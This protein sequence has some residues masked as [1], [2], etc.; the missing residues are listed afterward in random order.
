MSE[1]HRG[2]LL[3]AALYL[4][5]ALFANRSVLA[6]PFTL[7]P[8]P[9]DF[10]EA[11]K[12]GRRL[13]YEADQRFVVSQVTRLARAF[14]SD[15]M[16]L[17]D[18]GLC[19]PLHHPHTLGEHMFAQ[20]LVGALPYAATEDPLF[21]FNMVS[22]LTTWISLMCMYALAYYWTG[23][24]AAAFIAGLL[25]G[26]HPQRL[27]NPAHL[28]GF[29][30]GWSAIALLAAHRLFDR[31]R[32]ADA[33]LLAAALCLQLLE[34]FYPV[35]GLGIIGGTYGL[36]LSVRYARRIPRLFPKLASVAAVVGGFAWLVLGPYL[37]TQAAWGVL[38]GRQRMLVWPWQYLPGG[39]ASLGWVAFVLALLSL[40]DRLR[41]PRVQDDPRWPLLVAGILV[42]WCSVWAIPLPFGLRVKSPLL[43][44]GPYIPG[45]DAVRALSALQ[46]E[47]FLVASI[48]AAFAVVAI[49]E[50]VPRRAHGGVAAVITAATLV[51]TFY[52]P[53]ARATFTLTPDL[54]AFPMRPSEE[55]LAALDRLPSGAVLD[56]PIGFEPAEKLRWMPKYLL[57]AAYY[58]RPTAACYNSFLSGLQSEV[59]RRARELPSRAAARE[60]SAL[61]FGSLRIHRGDIGRRGRLLAPLLFDD[62]YTEPIL[63]TPDTALFR[64]H[65]HRYTQEFA[66]IASATPPR[67][68][69]SV[70]RPADDLVFRFGRSEA[71]TFR[72]PDPIE[73]SEVVVRWR[74]EDG[75]LVSE[76]HARTLL[77]PALASGRRTDR[78]IRVE[79][80]A[81]AGRYRAELV[82]A[83]E[84]DLVL[85]SRRVDVR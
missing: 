28:F 63:T 68:R 25:F 66:A 46:Y 30:N 37:D 24:F 79:A 23:S 64:L 11:E 19:A 33:A 29:G 4:G 67:A 49:L 2:A 61:G 36:W 43:L 83:A 58:D 17:T 53:A 5:V 47:V 39:T 12:P 85:A 69:A 82:R 51:Q 3:A 76:T 34:S 18:I 52:P 84:P 45:I 80:P 14:S 75:A 44:L 41:G 72:H 56:L 74:T 78:T 27:N 38:E 20:G 9:T 65:T 77:P 70:A 81:A 32:W 22:V 73:P 8:T 21:T 59:E 26:L 54:T 62:S 1:S 40:L 71:P 10:V 31:E 7:L 57:A 35:L 6:D 16:T 60:L 42:L 15:P 13:A 48:I 50:R 55:E